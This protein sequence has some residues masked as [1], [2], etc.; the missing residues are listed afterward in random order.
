MELVEAVAYIYAYLV[1][2]SS[3]PEFLKL[4]NEEL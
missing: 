3:T 4:L 2:D 1:E